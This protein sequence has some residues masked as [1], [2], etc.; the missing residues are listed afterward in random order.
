MLSIL[1]QG[2]STKAAGGSNSAL[3][4][5][6][7]TVMR[8]LPTA[9]D[10]HA[11]HPEGAT[12]A[13]APAV[14]GD[15]IATA[16]ENMPTVAAAP[17]ALSPTPSQM[18]AAHAE[19]DNSAGTV[20]DQDGHASNSATWVNQHDVLAYQQQAE[21][22]AMQAEVEPGSFLRDLKVS[23]KYKVCAASPASHLPRPDLAS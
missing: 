1:L 5:P 20:V 10:P 11:S 23:R 4:N 21:E 15:A 2:Y 6:S 3:D 9:A 13:V 19:A 7:R 22:A 12:A 17:L 16:V 8:P 18:P 14:P